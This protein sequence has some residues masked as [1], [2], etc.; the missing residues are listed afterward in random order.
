MAE[1][2]S[3]VPPAEDKEEEK[4]P[5]PKM[6]LMGAPH[7]EHTAPIPRLTPSRAHTPLSANRR[8]DRGKG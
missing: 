2:E 5:E 3:S 1:P 6:D 8:D 7:R 4:A